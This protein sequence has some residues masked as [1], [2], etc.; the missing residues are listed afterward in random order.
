MIRKA[1]A[2]SRLQVDEKMRQLE[3]AFDTLAT[4][5]P[6]KGYNVDW[7]RVE[8]PLLAVL[9]QISEMR[10]TANSSMLPLPWRVYDFF[11]GHPIGVIIVFL[12]MLIVPNLICS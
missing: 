4:Y 3:T 9:T 10:T 6:R 11:M 8:P 7:G 1:Y 5:K 12:A 2:N